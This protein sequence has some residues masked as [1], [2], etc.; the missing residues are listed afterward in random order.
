MQQI[1]LNDLSRFFATAHWPEVT[2]RRPTFFSIAGFPHYEN[3]MSNVYQFFFRTDSPHGMG[4]LCLDALLDV[5]RSKRPDL[6]RRKEFLTSVYALREVSVNSGQRLDIL[7]HNGPDET[8]WQEATFALLI[9]NKVYH[10]LANDLDNYWNSISSDTLGDQN[11]IAVVMGLHP[12]TLPSPWVYVSHLQWAKAIEARLGVVLYKAEPRYTTLLLELIENIRTMTNADESF[13]ELLGFFQQ[14]RTALSRAE[15]I[16]NDVFMRFPAA[17]KSALPEYEI[18][19]NVG[20]NREG[21][22]IIYKPGN[23]RF[24]YIL[25]YYE[26]FHEE[27]VIP[28]YALTL[29]GEDDHDGAEL[30]EQLMVTSHAQLIGLEQE[31]SAPHHVARK[32]YQVGTSNY[33]N[34]PE[35]IAASIRN[36]WQPL[37]RYWEGP[38]TE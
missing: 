14:N 22:L 24:K 17:I 1:S 32:I 33:E 8:D 31:N 20:A 9:E 36:E 11:K 27:N 38:S 7:L 35:I 25:G 19:A 10:W 5:I 29:V 18:W 21:W 3:V 4:S 28:S 2:E 16:R 30:Y 15:T 12:E 34:L 26:V 23:R 13:K 6:S 37:E